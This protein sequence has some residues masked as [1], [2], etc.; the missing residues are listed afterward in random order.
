MVGADGIHSTVRRALGLPFPG[1]PVVRSVMLAEVRLTQPP[2][3][4]LTVNTSGDAFALIAPFGDGWYRVIA[5][6]RR[7]QPP[8]DTPVYLAEVA[9]VARQVFGSDYGMHDPRWMS[10][11]HSEERQAPRYRDGRVLLAGDAAHIHSP[12]GGQGMNTGIQ[13]AANLGWKLAAT[14]QGWAQPGL[15][16][17]YQTER[18]PVGRQVLRTSHPLLRGPTAK[19]A[20]AAAPNPLAPPPTKL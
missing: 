1:K 16:D 10:R 5:W 4:A 15:L 9:E 14:V 3:H 7:N 19:P 17:T 13:D 2:P 20:F 8:E 12:A 11:F 18:H 6:H